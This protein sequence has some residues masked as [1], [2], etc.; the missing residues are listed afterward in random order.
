MRQL[1]QIRQTPMTINYSYPLGKYNIRQPKAELDINITKSEMTVKNDPIKA[2]IDQTPCFE[3][4]NRYNPVR[5]SEKI[6]AE[7][8]EVVMETIL[9]IG[10]DSK[11]MV[12]SKGEAHAEICKRKMVEYSLDMTTAYI[13][14]PPNISWE[15]GTPTKVDFTLF[16]INMNWHVNLKPEIDYERGRFNLSVAQWNKVD[17]AY[18]GTPDDVTK[19]GRNLN[20]KI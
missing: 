16:K 13:P 12:D 1:L 19:I 20:H 3:S 11:A 7:A 15:G 5:L 18:T 4:M 6:A 17:I 2:V 14:A 10:D 8:K 9:Q